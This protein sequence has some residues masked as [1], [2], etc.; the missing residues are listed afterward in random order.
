[1]RLG[2]LQFELLIFIMLELWF[3]IWLVGA[4]TSKDKIVKKD[5]EGPLYAPHPDLKKKRDKD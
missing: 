4:W 3:L 1:M 2:T 5:Y